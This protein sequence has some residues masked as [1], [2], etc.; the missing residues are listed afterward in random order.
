MEIACHWKNSA[1]KSGE[2][3][4]T[5]SDIEPGESP[6]VAMSV[7]ES[8]RG[9]EDSGATT[10]TWSLSLK[11]ISSPPKT[12]SDRPVDKS[13]CTIDSL[14]ASYPGCRGNCGV[15]EELKRTRPTLCGVRR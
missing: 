6:A 14:L 11:R 10:G 1:N 9:A 3:S 7:V 12:A 4:A 15:V 13:C 2:H 8:P 5:S